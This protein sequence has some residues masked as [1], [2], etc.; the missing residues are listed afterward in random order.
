MKETQLWV[1]F[2]PFGRRVPAVPQQWLEKKGPSR[3]V[4]G[5]RKGISV[6][7][8]D[9]FYLSYTITERKETQERERERE[10]EKRLSLNSQG[11]NLGQVGTIRTGRT[12]N[13]WSNVPVH[14]PSVE[15]ITWGRWVIV[16]FWNRSRRKK[17]KF[18]H[19]VN[20]Q[21]WSKLS[22]FGPGGRLQNSG[23]R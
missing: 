18:C 2:L 14:N 5:D 9:S 1:F 23:L 7:P 10:R 3:V 4:T 22:A 19:P 21:S 8:F 13:P 20:R 17:E 15:L 16:A 6:L 12:E 11:S